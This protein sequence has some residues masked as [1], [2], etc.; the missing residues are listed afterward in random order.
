MTDYSSNV[1]EMEYG[2]DELVRESELGV[3]SSAAHPLGW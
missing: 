1:E 3:R 2:K